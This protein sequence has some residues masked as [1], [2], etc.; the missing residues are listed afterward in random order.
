MSAELLAVLPSQLVP[1]APLARAVEAARA[2]YS[3]V[4]REL[5]RHALPEDVAAARERVAAMA[6]VLKRALRDRTEGLYAQNLLAESRLRLER[7]LGQWLGSHVNHSGGGDRRSDR[8][9]TTTGRDLPAGISKNQS[10]TFQ[11]LAAI[12]EVAFERYL[13]DTRDK[14]DEITTAGALRFAEQ[15]PSARDRRETRVE[16]PAGSPPFPTLNG[17]VESDDHGLSTLTTSGTRFGTVYVD[18]PWAYENEATR[19][20][21]V[22]HYPTLSVDAIAALPVGE[23]AAPDAHLHLWTT[24]A[25][26]FDCPRLLAAWGFTYKGVFVWVKPQVGL[27]NYWRVAHEFLVLGVRGRCPF[28]DHSARSWAELPRGRHSEKPDEVRALVERV[29]PG[30]YLELFARKP[31]PG[32]VV[33]GDEVTAAALEAVPAEAPRDRA[34]L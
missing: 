29:S 33:W 25:F 30:P 26:L 19:G 3:E 31:A 9:G 22:D 18:P 8:R 5:D 21:A 12:P 27:G 20:A 28:R 4:R 11:R 1:A 7:W 2:V 23:L 32:W 6:D 16:T 34:V 17:R 10:S 15:G 14:Q 24:N 13:T